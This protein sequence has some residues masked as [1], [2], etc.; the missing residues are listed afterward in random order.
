MQNDMENSDRLLS[1]LADIELIPCTDFLRMKSRT[2]L[3]HV[4]KELN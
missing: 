1:F 2:P 4:S 3:T